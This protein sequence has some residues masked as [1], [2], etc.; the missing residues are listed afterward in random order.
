MVGDKP[1]EMH[2]R[3][4]F[5][6]LTTSAFQLAS[7][8]THSSTDTRKRIG[9]FEH[10]IG[11]VNTSGPNQ[12]DVSRNVHAYGTGMLTGTLEEC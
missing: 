5:I 11:I 7:M 12:G 9:L 2:D 1:L 10:L 3:D 4:G 8:S 6:E